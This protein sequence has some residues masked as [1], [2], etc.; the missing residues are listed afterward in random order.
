[1]RR[2][3]FI[4]TPDGSLIEL[5][6]SASGSILKVVF[7]IWSHLNASEHILES[8]QSACVSIELPRHENVEVTYVD[9]EKWEYCDSSDDIFMILS[10]GQDWDEFDQYLVLNKSSGLARLLYHEGVPNPSLHDKS[11]S[12]L[13]DFFFAL[14]KPSIRGMVR[15]ASASGPPV[16]EMEP[17]DP[18]V[19]IVSLTY[20]HH[21]CKVVFPALEDDKDR[22]RESGPRP[23]CPRSGRWVLS[24]ELFSDQDIEDEDED[25]IVKPPPDRKSYCPY[26]IVDPLE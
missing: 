11:T 20:G 16:I 21:S 18:D 3:R 26:M 9:L 12:N 23:F 25:D 17:D 22:R 24:A 7:T 19:L 4:P 15:R 6:A 10:I 1:M 8:A 13:T 5:G 2:A 14:Y